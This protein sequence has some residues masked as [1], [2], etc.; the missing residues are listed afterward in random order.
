MQ[1]TPGGAK[2]PGQG[3]RHLGNLGPAVIVTQPS[4]LR[5]SFPEE[6]TFV[7]SRMSSGRCTGAKPFH[8]YS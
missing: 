8:N 7:P 4:E 5:G 6:G 3:T 2:C 1:F